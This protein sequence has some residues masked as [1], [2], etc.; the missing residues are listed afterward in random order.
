M[1]I[2]DKRVC[3]FMLH[4]YSQQLNKTLPD[5]RWNYLVFTIHKVLRIVMFKFLQFACLLSDVKVSPTETVNGLYGQLFMGKKLMRLI[6]L[7][8]NILSTCRI[9]MQNILSLILM[10]F[11]T[12]WQLKIWWRKKIFQV[13]FWCMKFVFFNHETPKHVPKQNFHLLKPIMSVAKGPFLP[14]KISSKC[15]FSSIVHSKSVFGF[16]NAL[17]KHNHYIID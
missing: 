4:I 9:A 3:N 16:Q 6:K 15:V 13:Q 2:F 10:Y 11:Y 7:I 5:Q 14:L 8:W 12:Y 1:G 17:I